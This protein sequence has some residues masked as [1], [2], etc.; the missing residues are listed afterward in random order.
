MWKAKAS[1]WRKLDNAAKIFPAT[2]GKR[3]TR[4]FRFSCEL[5]EEIDGILLQKALDVTMKGYPMFRSVM[6]KGL[7]WYYLEKS[8]L[9]P[10]VREEYK[11]PC[12]DLYIRDQKSLLFEV[13]YYKKRINFE[14]FHALT[15]GTGATLFL[16]ELVKNY[17]QEAHREEIP[18]EVPLLDED[19]TNHDK[20]DDSFSR[21]YDSSMRQA[22][23]KK[24]HS[25]QIHQAAAEGGGL[26]IVEGVVSSKGLLQKAREYGVSIS[27]FLTAVFLCAIHRE[28]SPGKE[29]YPVIL[30]VPVNLRK[31]FPSESMLN[32]FGWIEPGYRFESGKTSFEDVLHQVKDYYKEELTREKMAAR[33]N[34]YLSLERHP[35]L[36]VIPLEVKNLF[37]QA[38]ARMARNDVTA[39][40]SNM[41]VITMPEVYAKYIELFHVFTSTPKIELCMCSFEDRLVMSFTSRFENVNIQRNFF[42]ILEE[43]GVSVKIREPEY[44]KVED[45]PYVGK[46]FFQ[47]VTFLSIVISVLC[48]MCNVI[49]TP[50]SGWSLFVIGGLLCMWMI[51]AVGYYKRR[52]LLKN[53]LHQFVLITAAGILWDAFTGWR[54]WSLAYVFP[55]MNLLTIC[56]LVLLTKIQHLKAKDYMIYYFITALFGMCPI[57]CV[58]A[59][60][61]SVT[62]PSV[63][64]TGVS[65]LFFAALLIFRRKAFVFELTKKFHI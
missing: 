2:S 42:Q 29:R 49:L 39:I 38:G 5:K 28:M 37:M 35:L 58:L 57:A 21:Y 8:E 22:K 17:L 4:V 27:V 3:D 47:W 43:K 51:F 13:T 7:F 64:C 53:A 23:K 50:D 6:R 30:M 63:I 54:G 52:N 41:G 34:S 12:D 36:R 65:F 24:V 60:W 62:F 1:K 56:F 32:F 45:A 55:G 61:V 59:G 15:D 31:Y 10:Q 48:G 20:E 26:Q 9:M 16:K 18:E 40:F 25:Y 33:M 44:P 14:V 11:A 19:I 46:K